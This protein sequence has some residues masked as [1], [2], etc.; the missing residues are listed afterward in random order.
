MPTPVTVLVTVDASGAIKGSRE[1]Q[2]AITT[3]VNNIGGTAQKMGAQT[4]Q[5]SRFLERFGD[6]PKRGISA[7]DALNS[8]IIQATGGFQALGPASAAASTGFRGGVVWGR[9]FLWP[10]ANINLAF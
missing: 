6:A 3:A 5:A 1:A 8:T 2:Q 10:V 9:K 4:G 7:L